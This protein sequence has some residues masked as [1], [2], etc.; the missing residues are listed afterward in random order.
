MRRLIIKIIAGFTVG[1]LVSGYL[2][3]VR[4]GKPVTIAQASM[5]NQESANSIAALLVKKLTT[6]K[7][8]DALDATRQSLALG[9][10]ATWNGKTNITA[11]T[12]PTAST[13]AIP[14][15]VAKLALE[16]H[17]RAT[18]GTLTLAQLGNFLRDMGWP[19][20]SGSTP[21]EQL[22]RIF[23]AWV[24][25]AQ[26]KANDPLSFAPLF[27]REMALTQNPAVDLSGGNYQPEALRL[28]SLELELFSAHFDRLRH[29]RAKT[30]RAPGGELVSQA[31]AEDTCGGFREF[32]G[33]KGQAESDSEIVQQ[34]RDILQGE[35]FGA[36]LQQELERAGFTK[37]GAENFSKALDSLSI[38]GRLVKL[39]SLYK[40]A[41]VALTVESP[42]PIHKFLD[43]EG[44]LLSG[45]RARAGISDSD[46]NAYKDSITS[47]DTLRNMRGCFSQ[48]G[49]PVIPDLGDLGAE[50]Q[51][52]KVDWK[53]TEG[54]PEHALISLDVN[55]FYLP[56]QLEMILMPE[57]DHAASAMLVV[58]ITPEK[59]QAH[60]GT[61]K[62]ATVVAQASL[63]TAKPP[64]LDTL[65]NAIK[66]ATDGLALADALVSLGAGWFQEMDKPK[67]WAPLTVTYHEGGGGPSWTGTITFNDTAHSDDPK[68]T[69]DHWGRSSENRWVR[70]YSHSA[71]INING[72]K[73]LAGSPQSTQLW[74]LTNTA[75][76][77]VNDQTTYSQR[78]EMSGCDSRGRETAYSGGSNSE[79]TDAGGTGQAEATL[80][81]FGGDYWIAINTLPQAAGST[82]SEGTTYLENR[83][84]VL[85]PKQPQPTDTP[86]S[87][88]FPGFTVKGNADPKNPGLL[89]GQL[90][91]TNSSGH[92]ITITWHLQQVNSN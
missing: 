86:A 9:G 21:G 20:K 46:W 4:H 13:R 64:E 3:M 61:Q 87:V 68:S 5:P 85:Q 54:A 15:E 48:L 27:V 39:A 16:A 25:D 58:D 10:I 89:A 47:S 23:R 37:E 62:Q 73:M 53:L 29:A 69:R 2:L 32:M 12:A 19:F 75:T 43:S 74:N 80:T 82:H 92:K 63:R 30:A 36:L 56:G 71:T 7:F 26:K 49:L 57:N 83:P 45:F 91:R 77:I 22:R 14:E 28:T 6:G 8:V 1:L 31:Y 78:N 11:A 52:W 35:A 50:V 70:D 72:S 66:G 60:T 40:N 41:L 38:A 33:E 51:G 79:K 65:V 34:V 42:N 55:Q 17:Q 88:Y 59:G 18:A 44:R 24:Q 81:L 67:A 90:D 84:C 76:V